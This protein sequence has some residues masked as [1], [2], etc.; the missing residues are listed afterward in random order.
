MKVYLH[1]FTLNSLMCIFLD[2][3]CD[4]TG[5]KVTCLFL[6]NMYFSAACVLY[7]MELFPRSLLPLPPSP[8]V[9]ASLNCVSFFSFLYFTIFQFIQVHLFF[10]YCV[11]IFWKLVL[12]IPLFW[13]GKAIISR[14]SKTVNNFLDIAKTLNTYVIICEGFLHN[15]KHLKHKLTN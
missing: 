9:M 6:T 4:Y 12:Y 1:S 8:D 2:L 10:M 14:P 13:I 11:A 3:F 7:L 15:T 5:A